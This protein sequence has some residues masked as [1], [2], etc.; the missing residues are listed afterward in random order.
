MIRSVRGARGPAAGRHAWAMTDAMAQASPVAW[1]RL[2]GQ[3]RPAQA[4]NPPS[5][6]VAADKPRSCSEAAARLEVYPAEHFTMTCRSSGPGHG[7]RGVRR[8]VQALLATLRAI[9]EQHS[10]LSSS[11]PALTCPT[12]IACATSSMCIL[13]EPVCLADLALVAGMRGF[14]L[15]RQFRR[16]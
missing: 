9:C 8:G 16:Y 2:D 7:Q 12:F 1:S 5:R 13:P 11:P 14:P 4:W 10:Q 15:I 3:P 6:S